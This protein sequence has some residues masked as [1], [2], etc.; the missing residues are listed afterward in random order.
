MHALNGLKAVEICR[1]ETVDM[2]LM[3][4]KMPEV[5]GYEAALEIRKIKPVL[6]IIAQTAVADQAEMARYQHVFDDYITKPFTKE[7]LI[8]VIDRY[9]S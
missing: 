1:N 5:N 3:D 6:P 2:V 4:I 8:R 9:Y 7:K